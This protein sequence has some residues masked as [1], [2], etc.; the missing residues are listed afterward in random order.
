M[1]PGKIKAKM[2]VLTD[3]MTMLPESGLG[4]MQKMLNHD[5]LVC[6]VC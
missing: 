5:R 2:S 1:V 3:E 6:G 4:K